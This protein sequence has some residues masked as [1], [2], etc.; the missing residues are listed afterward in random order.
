M[1]KRTFIALLV[2]AGIFVSVYLT[3]SFLQQNNNSSPYAT[4]GNEIITVSILPIKYLVDNIGGN[5]FNVNV[6]VPPGSTPES[7]EPT[8]GQIINMNDSKAVFTIGLIDFETTLVNKAGKHLKSDIYPLYEGMDIVEGHCSHGHEGHLHGV[9]PHIWTSFRGVKVMAF[10]VLEALA[11]L[12]PGYADE[13]RDN[14]DALINKIE[15][16]DEQIKSELIAANVYSFLIYHPVLT[17]YSADYGLGQIA[18]EHEGKE[19]S[20]EHMKTII[21]KARKDDIKT[22]LYQ[23]ESGIG[24]V[25]TIAK[26]IGAEPVEIDPMA[27]NLLDNIMH[28]TEAIVSSK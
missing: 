2:F 25:R 28:I 19:P 11:L 23:K 7:Y 22:V 4:D 5:R 15:V 3:Y 12:Y 24:V 17:Y 16:L 20:V 26:D 6:L 21:D 1:T 8:S 13:F 9:D 27:E 10:N 18:L 14:Y